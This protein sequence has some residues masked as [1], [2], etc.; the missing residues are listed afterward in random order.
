VSLSTLVD[1][2]TM[3]TRIHP[4]LTATDLVQKLINEL[5]TRD[6][7]LCALSLLFLCKFR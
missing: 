6:S 2:E 3:L 4:E 5:A 7:P 1:S